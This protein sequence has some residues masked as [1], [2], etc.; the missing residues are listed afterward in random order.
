[1][2]RKKTEK[3]QQNKLPRQETERG[4]F[5]MPYKTITLVADCWDEAFLREDFVEEVGAKMLKQ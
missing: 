3:R 1:M 5:A 4:K 2:A